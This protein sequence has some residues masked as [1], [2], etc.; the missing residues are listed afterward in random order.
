MRAIVPLLLVLL[1]ACFPATTGSIYGQQVTQEES[2]GDLEVVLNGE[3]FT[4]GQTI[5]ISGSI[6]DPGDQPILNIE[7]V[8][9]EGGIVERA[10][11][12][13]TADN[14]FTFSFEAGLPDPSLLGDKP[15]TVSG[16]YRV[17]VTYVASITNI[18]EVDLEF[19]Y[20][21]T[22]A[23][24]GGANV[25]GEG[26][27]QQQAPPTTSG[28]G[29]A[30]TGIT[31]QQAVPSPTLPS[32]TF[33]NNV[34]GIRVGVPNG[35]VFEDLNNT[36]PSLQQGEQN[37]GAGVLVELCP[38]T[39]ATPQIG[40]TYL[41][42]EAEEG[43]ESVSVWRFADL[44]SRPE[45]AG[46]VERNQSI[47][48][49]DLMAYYFL[50]LEQKANYTNFTALENIDTTVNVIDPQTSA[51]IATAPAKYIETTYVD[52]NGIANEGDFAFLVLANDGNT[53]YA[54]LP[55][56]SL[57]PAAGQLPPEHQ[58]VFDTFELIATNG[59]ADAAIAGAQQL[60]SPLSE[61]SQ[62]E[63]QRLERQQ[64][65][66]PLSPQVP[67]QQPLQ[68]QQQT[69]QSDTSS[70]SSTEN[71]NTEDIEDTTANDGGPLDDITQPLEDLFG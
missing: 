20:I 45:F 7:I 30:A 63:Q 10:S 44:K 26:V 51:N 52:A 37:Y 70:S 39:Q 59:T 69:A 5:T 23:P 61:Q 71:S 13:I 17:T 41:C 38:Q 8:D 14:T 11:P 50:F 62:Q 28:G 2:E 42:P 60:Q 29:G 57:M 18:D 3:V 46:V 68:Q 16:N 1:L 25:S 67:Q 15:M 34:D 49:N 35:W 56:T 58:L 33:Q 19:E 55:I 27:Q 54:V 6:D 47:T 53:G 12:E 65:Q 36:D 22:P 66:Q 40:G 4:T 48:T 24:E 32:A 43:L 31:P 9:P 64:M 21:V